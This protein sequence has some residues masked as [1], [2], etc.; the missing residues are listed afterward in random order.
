MKVKNRLA[1][2][3]AAIMALGVLALPIT[4]SAQTLRQQSDQRQKQKNTWRNLAIGAGA[5]A[6]YGL[7]KKDKM[8]TLGGAAGAGYSLYRYEQDRKSQSDIDTRRSRYYYGRRR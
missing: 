3:L 7:L 6:L 4:A 5:V 8:L 2:L 1:G